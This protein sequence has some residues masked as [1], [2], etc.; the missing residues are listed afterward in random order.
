[1]TSPIARVLRDPWL[2]PG[3]VALAAFLLYFVPGL[4]GPYGPFIDELYYVANSQWSRF[5]KDGTIFP[6]DKLQF[7]VT[8][9]YTKRNTRWAGDGD[10]SEG[11]LLNVGRGPFN[12]M[13]GG[14]GADCDGIADDVGYISTGGGA[15]L[16]FLEGKTLPAVAAL[17]ARGA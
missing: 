17:E 16:E 5:D 7:Q 8:T 2:V 15:F 10:N 14:K 12:Y 9:A 6:M 1:M 4:V 11:F 3:A 13:K